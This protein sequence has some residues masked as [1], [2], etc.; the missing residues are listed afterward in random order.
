MRKSIVV[1]LFILLAIIAVV[2]LGVAIYSYSQIQLVKKSAVSGKADSDA[3]MIEKISTVMQLP[4]EKPTVINVTDREKLQS[5]EFFKKAE[6]GDKVII[7]ESIRR[8]YLYRPSIKK[9]IDVAPLVF[10]EQQAASQAPT[11]PVEQQKSA[12]NSADMTFSEETSSPSGYSLPA[13]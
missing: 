7:Y 1:T 12:S 6:N 13:E 10:N 5:Q 9:I 4:D 8:I 3:L 11:N 2:S